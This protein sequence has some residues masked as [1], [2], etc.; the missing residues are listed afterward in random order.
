MDKKAAFNFN[1]FLPKEFR[2]YPRKVQKALTKIFEQIYDRILNLWPLILVNYYSECF[3][4]VMGYQI[5]CHFLINS[6]S[7]E[8]NSLDFQQAFSGDGNIIYYD[9]CEKGRQ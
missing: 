2:Y 4:I 6:T 3:R 9:C 5:I 1:F 8:L 7:S